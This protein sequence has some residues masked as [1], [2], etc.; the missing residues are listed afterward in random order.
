MHSSLTASSASLC[1]S[2]SCHDHLPSFDP[3]LTASFSPEPTKLFPP[4]VSHHL[5]LFGSHISPLGF[6]G[7]GIGKEPACE[8]KRDMGSVPGLGR[9]TGEGNDNLF[10][11]SCLE[12]PMGRGAYGL[13]STGSQRVGH[14][15][16]DWLSMHTAPIRFLEQPHYLACLWHTWSCSFFLW[17]SPVPLG[18][19][20]ATSPINVSTC[21]GVCSIAWLD[22]H[23]HWYG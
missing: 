8:C 6:S 17:A 18:P 13:Q 12:N 15:W 2:P 3:T 7:G 22:S 9:S 19:S 16:S 4:S 10:Q 20:S 11:Y 23:G 1:S 21:L 5:V 14:Y